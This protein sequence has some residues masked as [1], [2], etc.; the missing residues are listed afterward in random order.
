[1]SIEADADTS[2]SMKKRHYGQH[3]KGLTYGGFLESTTALDNA[4][5]IGMGGRTRKEAMVE[6]KG[7]RIGEKRLGV[8]DE[9]LFE[10]CGGRTAHK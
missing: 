6:K 1:M 4:A 10:A 9:L 5:E 3:R 7:R 2:L 8:T